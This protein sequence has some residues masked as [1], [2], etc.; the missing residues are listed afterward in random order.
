[1]GK[2]GRR[3][4]GKVSGKPAKRDR[5]LALLP[6]GAIRVLVSADLGTIKNRF[7]ERMH[8]NLPAPVE[9]MPEKKHGVFDG[10]PHDYRFDGVNG[11]ASEP[12]RAHKQSNRIMPSPQAASKEIEHTRWSRSTQ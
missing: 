9:R 10:E 8:G 5:Q 11:D 3:P 12:A 7:R 6:D 2:T 1:M 4:C